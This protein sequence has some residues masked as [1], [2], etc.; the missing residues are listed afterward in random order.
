[1]KYYNFLFLLPLLL[2]CPTKKNMERFFF[3]DKNIKATI[4]QT[5]P[6]L[7]RHM[8]EKIKR[9]APSRVETGP[10]EAVS[11]YVK[12][13]NT[14]YKSIISNDS[15]QNLEVYLFNKSDAGG[16]QSIF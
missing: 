2:D 12:Y 13:G 9:W 3:K 10:P 1:M 5:F 8:T 14:Y 15:R 6:A 16:S 7:H 11:S 4:I